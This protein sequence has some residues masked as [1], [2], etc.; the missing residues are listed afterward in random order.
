MQ[1]AVVR[2]L[3]APPCFEQFRGS[4]HFPASSGFGSV[5]ID[6]IMRS[7]A[8]FLGV[9]A[10]ANFQIATQSAPLRDVE[11]M[12]NSPLQGARLVFLPS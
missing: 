4:H 7:V 8:E 11:K 9:A 2:A 12:W 5:A 1:A 3:S 10:T 6:A